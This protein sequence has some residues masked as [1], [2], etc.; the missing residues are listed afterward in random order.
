[1][2]IGAIRKAREMGINVP[3]DVSV[4]GFDDIETSSLITPSLTTISQHMRDIGRVA[5]E[6]AISLS[7]GKSCTPKS[8]PQESIIRIIDTHLVVRESSARCPR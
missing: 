3:G 4:V 5:A 1:M 8:K 6:V 2:A 7:Q